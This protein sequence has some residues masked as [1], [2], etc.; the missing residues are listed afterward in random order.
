MGVI[1]KEDFY[2][3]AFLSV[4]LSHGVKPV[5]FDK[6]DTNRIYKFLTDKGD[7]QIYMKYR[8]NATSK[9]T[10]KT[11]LW[12]FVFSKDEVER[13]RKLI[14]SDEKVYFGFICGRKELKNSEIAILDKKELENSL[15]LNIGMD[16]KS[17]SYRISIKY[18]KNGHGLRAYG[19]GRADKK[20]GEDNAFIIERDRISSL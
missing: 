13:I 6:T 3:G 15:G 12:Q 19:T 4:L 7:Y 2:Y 20:E 17:Y 9:K 1:N 16:S 5:L 11:D 14:R 10:N 18:I 8:G